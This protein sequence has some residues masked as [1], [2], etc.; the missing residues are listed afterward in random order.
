MDSSGVFA[1]LATVVTG[2]LPLKEVARVQAER[3]QLRETSQ[4]H[5]L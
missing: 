3:R 4:A 1:L 5:A 2:L